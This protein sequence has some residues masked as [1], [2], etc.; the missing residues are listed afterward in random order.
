MLLKTALTALAA[1]SASTA[2][3]SPLAQVKRTTDDLEWISKNASLP[4]VM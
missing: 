3:A 2:L 1:L 4:K